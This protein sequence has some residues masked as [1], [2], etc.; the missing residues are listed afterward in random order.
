M[1]IKMDIKEAVRTRHSVRQY[2]DLPIPEDLVDSLNELIRQCNDES[3]LH[4]Q[5]I[6]DDPEC[7]NTLL[8]HYGWFKN[9]RN[10]IAIVGPR[11]LPDLEEKGG[12][13]GQKIVIAAQQRGLNTCWVAGTYK[14]GKCHVDRADNEKIVCVIAIGFGENEG[15]KHKSR[16]LAKL[17]SVKEEDM[18]GWFRNGVKAAMMAPTAMN[19]QKF[20]ISLDGGEALITSAPGPMTKIDLGIVKYNFEAVSGHSCR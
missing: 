16:P 13:Y 18:P 8:A 5:L 11:T 1:E 4:I 3:G 9:V 14:K 7:F 10:Y 12:Y 20:K 6:L 2:K 19:Q 17:C 15:T